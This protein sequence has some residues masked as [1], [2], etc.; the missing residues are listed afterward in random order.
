MFCMLT[1]ELEQPLANLALACLRGGRDC[2][3]KSL[4]SRRRLYDFSARLLRCPQHLGS[5]GQIDI[6]PRARRQG[7][8]FPIKPYGFDPSFF[9]ESF[10][11]A[12]G[13][14]GHYGPD[15]IYTEGS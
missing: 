8:E 14:A 1:P 7:K 3:S 6:Q 5:L 9:C 11:C 10:G 4:A 13:G 12:C 2:Y 15:R